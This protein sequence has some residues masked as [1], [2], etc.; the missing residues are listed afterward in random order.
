MRALK[1]KIYASYNLLHGGLLPHDVIFSNQEGYVIDFD[2]TSL[3]TILISRTG[4]R[5]HS[6]VVQRK[7]W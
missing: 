6:H 3:S 1:S 4:I 2:L 5:M 7:K